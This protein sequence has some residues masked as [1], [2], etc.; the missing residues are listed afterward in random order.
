[1]KLLTQ[2][3]Y[4]LEQDM[5]SVTPTSRF[6]LKERMKEVLE[7]DK[8]SSRKCD[9]FG[10]S[11]LSLDTKIEIIDE[12][13]KEL[14]GI[15]ERLR[16]AKEIA[17]DVGAELFGEYGIYKLEGAGISSISVYQPPITS[18][19]AITVINEGQLIEA[20]FVKK[21][22]DTDAIKEA[23]LSGQYAELIQAH[24][25]IE[26]QNIE[27]PKRLRIN[28]RRSSIIIEQEQAS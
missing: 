7:S 5:Q 8:E 14:R 11:F 19:L 16:V 2:Q 26:L 25:T 12:E 10:Y 15:K 23:Y 6:R 1:M 9:Y 4:Q 18:K 24:C 17:L 20:G 27:H 22:V 3:R 28:K 21:V 13:I